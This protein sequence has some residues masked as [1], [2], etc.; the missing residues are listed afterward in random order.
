[1]HV[2]RNEGLIPVFFFPL[3]IHH[4]IKGDIHLQAMYSLAVNLEIACYGFVTFKSS[5]L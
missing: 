4:D 3:I 2:C 5:F 1:M